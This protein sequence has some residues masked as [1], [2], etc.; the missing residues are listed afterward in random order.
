MVLHPIIMV[1]LQEI[2]Q[3]N[4]SRALRTQ[5]LASIGVDLRHLLVVSFGLSLLLLLRQDVIL[6]ILVLELALMLFERRCP[7]HAAPLSFLSEYFICKL[8]V[9]NGFDEVPDMDLVSL[10]AR[11]LV[12]QELGI[13]R[14]GTWLSRCASSSSHIKIACVFFVGYILNQMI[15]Y[16]KCL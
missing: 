13:P 15:I 2:G 14:F 11:F 9:L 8:I 10:S 12:L 3:R 16:Y 1:P 4:E 5:L 6:K 7:S